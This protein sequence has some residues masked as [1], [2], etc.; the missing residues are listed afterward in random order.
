MGVVV[1]FAAFGLLAGGC[2]AGRGVA[3]AQCMNRPN[4]E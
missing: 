1:V 2:V 3:A 4:D